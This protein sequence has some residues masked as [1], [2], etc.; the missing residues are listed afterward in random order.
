MLN[1]KFF[2]IWCLYF[3]IEIWSANIEADEI[4]RVWKKWN[5]QMSCLWMFQKVGWTGFEPATPCTPYKCATGL[6]HHPNMRAANVKENC[7]LIALLKS[8]IAI[9]SFQLFRNNFWKKKEISLNLIFVEDRISSH[10][11]PVLR[12]FF[13]LLMWLLFKNKNP[14]RAV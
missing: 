4:E 8:L 14:V 1:D 12:L 10:A 2:Q 11:S 9:Q 3:S 13:N 5:I 7:L 6:R